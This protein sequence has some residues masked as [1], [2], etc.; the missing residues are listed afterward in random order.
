MGD[1]HLPP[2]GAVSAL[3]QVSGALMCACILAVM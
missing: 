1:A 3:L 2:T